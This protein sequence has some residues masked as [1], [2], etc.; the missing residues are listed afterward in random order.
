M[1]TPTK[2]KAGRPKSKQR[3]EVG[4]TIRHKVYGVGVALRQWGSIL[5]ADERGKSFNVP[6]DKVF[7]VKFEGRIY[8][9]SVDSCRLH[10]VRKGSA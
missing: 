4:S 6:A 1:E 7:D 8:P 9:I 3:I 10:L 5:D 2:S